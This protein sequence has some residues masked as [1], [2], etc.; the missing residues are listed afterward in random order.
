V[1]N[2]G[3]AINNDTTSDRRDRSDRGTVVVL[4]GYGSVGRAVAHT[5]AEWFPGEVVVAGRDG[6]RAQALASSSGGAITA[7]QVD[8]TRPDDVRRVLEG[9][10]VVVMC[11][12]RAN[13]SVAR[14]CLERGI[15]YVDV[16]ASDDLLSAIAQLD[17]L[18][19][20]RDATA[21]LS[22]G[23]AP[24]LTNL[25]A[26]RA[27]ERLPSAT[28]IDI[29]L[30]TGVNGDHGPDA[31]RWIIANLSAAP[32]GEAGPLRVDLPGFGTRTAHPFP[33]SD[34]YAVTRALGVQTTSRLAF[35]SVILT[36]V[37]FGLRSV[38]FFR[39]LRR[40][41][42]RRLLTA[43]LS[44]TRFGTDRFVA[45]ASATDATGARVSF[46]AAGRQEGRA[47][48]VVAAHVARLLREG[49]APAGVVHIDD[50]GDTA[51]LLHRLER[52]GITLH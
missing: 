6:A 34:Q 16:S 25:L 27:Y 51:A 26:R 50:L 31:L 24:G 42:A 8:V 5:L 49:D 4:G 29:T 28:R 52:H 44:R 33:F 9:A 3:V 41:R 30:I 19:R 13:E 38:R 12:E 48:G 22:V 17:P 1:T 18:A 10:R 15:H 36:S 7:R 32:R 2:P 37:I 46:A 45:Q 40:L 35:E 43:V 21:V 23:L 11:I 20:K 14:A 47:T 39:L